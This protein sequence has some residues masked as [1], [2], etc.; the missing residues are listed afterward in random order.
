MSANK[1]VVG[2]FEYMDDAIGAMELAKSGGYNY[3]V[4]SPVPNHHLDHHWS[5]DRSPV[6][7]LSLIGGVSGLVF[8]FALAIMCSLD[9]PLRTSAKDIVSVPA[10]VVIGYECTILF[11]ALFTLVAVGLFGK[12]YQNL[13]V[14]QVG[15]SPRFSNDRFGVVVSCKPEDL[16]RV[17]QSMADAGAEDVE[18]QEAL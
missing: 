16:D 3:K 8:G 1:A 13:L 4:Y 5:P 17:R 11:T 14:R 7:F 9:Y 2:T 18:V 15:Y 6:R 12:L 10:F